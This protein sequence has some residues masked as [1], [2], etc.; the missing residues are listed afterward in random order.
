MDAGRDDED[1]DPAADRRARKA[2]SEQVEMAQRGGR[3]ECLENANGG[4]CFVPWPYMP[5][6]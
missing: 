4:Q 5:N 6:S 2:G 1:A 3:Q